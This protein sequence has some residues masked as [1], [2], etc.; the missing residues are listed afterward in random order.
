MVAV[1]NQMNK[2]KYLTFAT[3]ALAL[4]GFIAGAAPFFASLPPGEAAKSATKVQIKL[5][6]IPDGG[7]GFS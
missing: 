3:V 6:G 1:S 2:R 7:S 5:L 4:S